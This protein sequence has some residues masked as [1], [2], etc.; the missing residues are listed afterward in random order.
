M[1]QDPADEL[2]VLVRRSGDDPPTADRSAA[3]L[4]R[5]RFGL[6]L[7]PPFAA[8]PAPAEVVPVRSATVDDGPAIAAVKWRSWRLAYR[9]IVPDAFLA[10]LAVVPP[11]HD[12]MRRLAER[13]RRSAILVAG[14]SGSVVGLTE[15]RPWEGDD[16]DGACT[17]QIRVCY[18]DPLVARRG[19]GTALLDAAITHARTSG[20]E[21]L[22]LWVAERNVTARRF[23]EAG[24]WRTDGARMRSELTP[25]VAMDEVRYRLGPEP[26]S[27]PGS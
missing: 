22:R 1:I 13:P 20:L 14:R 17:G 7:P 18:V 12:W 15:V 3:A 9:G 4:I 19:I 25:E 11:P 16:L 5:R 10:D 8:S 27:D 26:S 21:D 6:S 2:L 23:Y 24:G